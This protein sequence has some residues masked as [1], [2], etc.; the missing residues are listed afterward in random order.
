[1]D[2]LNLKER[3]AAIF[4]TTNTLSDELLKAGSD[5]P[6]LAHGL[7]PPLH[8]N[9]PES[10]LKKLKQQ[11]LEMADEL[12]ALLTEPSMHLAPLQ[13]LPYSVHP[14]VRLGITEVFPEQGA[15]VSDIALSAGL[16]ESLVRRLLAHAATYHVF[17]EAEPDFYVHTAASRLLCQSQPVRDWVY[18][19]WDEMMPAAFKL[20]EALSRYPDS[21]EPEHCAWNVANNTT[22]PIFQVFETHP[23]RAK[24]FAGAMVW[25]ASYPGFEPEH[26]IEGFP[27]PVPP[28]NNDKENLKVID[29][30]GGRGHIS[31]A[32]AEHSPTTKFIV[33]DVPDIV[34]QGEES[35]PETSKDAILF[36]SHDFFEPQPVEGADIYLLRQILHDWSDKYAMKIIRALIP[37]LKSGAKVVVNDRVMPG[38]REV[39]YLVEREARDSDMSMLSFQN[40]QERSRDDWLALFRAADERFEVTAIRKPDR[41]VLSVI[42]VTWRG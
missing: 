11:L 40:A 10:D 28:S 29:V 22:K 2:A 42:E 3:A 25:Y 6:S 34:A 41:S 39:H 7:P 33:Q 5:E 23:E 1:M 35:L 38:H 8:A 14:I 9:A 18:A 24:H 21:Q 13:R 19:G 16:R 31:I 27:W 32:L 30:G 4:E 15:T 20:G 17:F 37:A 36:Q 26:L 12:R